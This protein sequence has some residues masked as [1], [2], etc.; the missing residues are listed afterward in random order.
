M[1]YFTSDTHYGHAN[2]IKYSKRPF[3]HVDEMNEALIKNWNS[4]VQPGDTVYH[5]G[6]FAFA[7][8]DKIESI[9]G[10]LKGQKILLWGNHDKSLW[11]EKEML[12]RYFNKVGDYFELN[13]PDTDVDRGQRKVVMC[14]YPMITWNKAHYGAFMLHGHCHGSLRYPFVGKILDVG[15]DVHNYPPISYDQVKAILGPRKTVALDHHTGD[16]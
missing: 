13:V 8:P 4:V 14:H 3:A 7:R 1:I 10:R 2:I 12:K 5:L 16:M 15:V 9:L 11:H 6:D